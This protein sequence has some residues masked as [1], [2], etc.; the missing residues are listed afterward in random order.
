MICAMIVTSSPKFN[1][2][3]DRHPVDQFGYV[4]IV[5]VLTTNTLPS[6]VPEGE[7][8]SNGIQDPD[9]ILG[10]PTD[11]F[12]ALRMEHTLNE[13]AAAHGEENKQDAAPAD[14]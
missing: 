8:A 1:K 9:S 13:Y 3:R 10:R 14:A 2:R 7:N 12:E 6:S 11:V 4:D 5:K